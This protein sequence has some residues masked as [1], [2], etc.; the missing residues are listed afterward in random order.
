[1]SE[2]EIGPLL[3]VGIRG[4]TPGDATLECDL[5][6]CAEAGVGAVIL[7]DVDV[8]A[9]RESLASGVSDARARAASPRNILDPEQLARLVE[10]LRARLGAGI[11]VS[12][13]QE[14][15][16]V[17]RLNPLR[18][19]A[20][21]PSAAEFARMDARAQAEAADRQ[22]A[23]LH[24]LGID[25]NFAP[26]VDLALEPGN[27]VIVGAGR[28]FG[29]EARTV[30]AAARVVLDAHA[31]HGVAACLKHFP[32]HGSSRGDTHEGV[33][34]VTS[35][36][37]GSRELVPYRE[38]CGRSGVAVMAAHVLH[39]EIDAAWPA[40]LSPAWIDGVL[41]GE[42]G[43]TGVVITDSID[44]RAIA[45]RHGAGEAA[46]AAIRAGAD[47]VVDGFNLH[48]RDRHP[49]PELAA[50]LRAAIERGTL[51]RER[52]AQS[53][54]RLRRLRDEVPQP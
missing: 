39:R 45:T 25:L 44:M 47:L 6:C 38:L 32:G 53:R 15:G 3:C 5:D 22:A 13:D 1:M 28:S 50:A 23:R 29:A 24:D 17:A 9:W 46:V 14:G 49:A 42:L 41:R 33:V 16:R 54:A 37:D 34:D 7:F 27:E 40:S 19:F 20:A 26:C 4:A 31:R 52:I 36:W 43:F 8:P 2:S 18:R 30:V 21:D 48:A 35:S 10:H 12:I 11:F 51:T